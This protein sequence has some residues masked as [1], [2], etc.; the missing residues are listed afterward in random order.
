[1]QS[2]AD[3]DRKRMHGT[4]LG[5]HRLAV[6]VQACGTVVRRWFRMGVNCFRYCVRAR[7]YGREVVRMHCTRPRACRVG[8]EVQIA[9]VVARV[10][11]GSTCGLIPAWSPEMAW[12]IA[13]VCVLCFLNRGLRPVDSCGVAPAPP[14]LEIDSASYITLHY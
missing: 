2:P 7:A 14:T 12:G 3:V 1:M 8:V 9:T 13:T 4:Q 11:I 10:Q 6:E 5:V